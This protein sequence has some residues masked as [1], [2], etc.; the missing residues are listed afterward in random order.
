MGRN[1]PYV[2]HYKTT[3]NRV[4]GVTY[5]TV[6]RRGP[7]WGPYR[8]P[9]ESGIFATVIFVVVLFWPFCLNIKGSTELTIALLWWA[10]LALVICASRKKKA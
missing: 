9:G 5:R 6:Q 2:R 3:A 4:N 7:Y 1:N 10:L 8:Q